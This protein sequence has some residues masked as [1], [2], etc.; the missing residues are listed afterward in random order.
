MALKINKSLM[1]NSKVKDILKVYPPKEAN[2]MGLSSYEESIRDVLSTVLTNEIQILLT[3]GMKSRY[4]FIHNRKN[5]L[6]FFCIWLCELLKEC[7]ADYKLKH[8][9]R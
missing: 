2:L 7:E 1:K 3:D 5:T 4:K 6:I 9:L 8:S